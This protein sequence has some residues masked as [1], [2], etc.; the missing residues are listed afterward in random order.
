MNGLHVPPSAR[1]NNTSKL[2]GEALNWASLGEARGGGNDE[3]SEF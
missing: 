2:C 3:A 1:A